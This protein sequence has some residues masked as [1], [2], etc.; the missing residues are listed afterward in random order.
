LI[1]YCNAK[2]L[3]EICGRKNLIQT[4]FSISCIF[5]ENFAKKKKKPITSHSCMAGN[6]GL[7]NVGT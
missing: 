4:T 1:N 5:S 6:S 2:T 7:A 3:G